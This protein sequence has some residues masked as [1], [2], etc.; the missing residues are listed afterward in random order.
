MAPAESPKNGIAAIMNQINFNE[1]EAGLS[2]DRGRTG[3]AHCD[4]NSKLK[5][6]TAKAKATTAFSVLLEMFH[7]R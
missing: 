3:L 4:P 2:Q 6:I 7:Q 1:F 5:V